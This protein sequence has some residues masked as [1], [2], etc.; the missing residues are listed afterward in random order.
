MQ[1]IMINTDIEIK[2]MKNGIPTT[3]L[4][5][6]NKYK[7]VETFGEKIEKIKTQ[8][9]EID[10]VKLHGKKHPSY[11]SSIMNWIKKTDKTVFTA[12]EIIKN[13][14]KINTSQLNTVISYM[15][16]QGLI[17]QINNFSFHTCND[18]MEKYEEIYGEDGEK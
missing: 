4:I 15:I 16:Q 7:I 12:D 2:D 5:D 13:F 10:R 17:Y 6:E 8:F 14:E 9:E 3:I 1:K 18:F 11:F